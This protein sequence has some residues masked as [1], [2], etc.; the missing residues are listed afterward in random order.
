MSSDCLQPKYATL[1]DNLTDCI[2][3]PSFGL[4]AGRLHSKVSTL[5][6]ASSPT[7][8]QS[9][10]FKSLASN[11]CWKSNF[12]D[13]FPIERIDRELQKELFCCL[14]MSPAFRISVS[15][16]AYLENSMR[17]SYIGPHQTF[18]LANFGRMRVSGL[19]ELFLTD[20]FAACRSVRPFS[21][22]K[23]ATYRRLSELLS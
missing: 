2:Y 22:G 6:R 20:K 19:S 10:S 5:R 8:R 23:R 15:V 7:S 16:P 14:Q 11:L 4:A 18:R 1:H 9:E 12:I 21:D 3:F 17:C 13:G